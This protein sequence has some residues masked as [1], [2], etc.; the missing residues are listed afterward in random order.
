MNIVRCCQME[1]S[2]GWKAAAGCSSPSPGLL[3]RIL[4]AT[5]DI[6]ERRQ[7]EQSLREQW[8]QPAKANQE[9][10]RFAYVVSH[11]LKE[12]LRGITAMT[13]L[14]F[15]RT[16]GS[17]A[18]E[19]TEL[20]DF[21]LKNRQRMRQLISDVLDLARIGSDLPAST[22]E[23]DVANVIET[24]IDELRG[25]IDESHARIKVDSM[26]TSSEPIE[27]SL[28]ACWETCSAMRSNIAVNDLLRY[29]WMHGQKRANGFFALATMVLELIPKTRKRY[30][31]LFNAF[32]H[33]GIR[34]DR[35]RPCY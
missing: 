23:V 29:R 10:E 35:T 13:E 15:R 11:D 4:G 9:L 1:V 34:G 12:P 24:A 16:R 14:F 28:C 21:I 22:S 33:G 31:A 7:L 25:A 5:I 17:L 2:G 18:P 30:L 20:L 3:D 8:E 19:S 27:I 26:P 32:M 6:T